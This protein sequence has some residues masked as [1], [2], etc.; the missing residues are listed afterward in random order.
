MSAA[1]IKISENETELDAFST[2]PISVIIL[3]DDADDRQLAMHVCEHL[4]TR[5]DKDTDLQFNWWRTCFLK[6]EHLAGKA[7]EDAVMADVMIVAMD[8]QDEVSLDLRKWFESWVGIRHDRERLL[9]D[10]TRIHPSIP[11]TANPTYHFLHHVAHRARMD[12]LASA[13]RTM[14]QIMPYPFEQQH[15]KS[16][17]LP[18]YDFEQISTLEHFGLNE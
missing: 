11:F 2:G 17:R 7:L 4:K 6:D 9:V 1:A 5:L 16:P 13:N 8:T 3:Y 15:P 14:G 18:D 10:L 12:Y